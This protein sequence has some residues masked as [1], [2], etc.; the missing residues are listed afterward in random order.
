MQR[1]ERYTYRSLPNVARFSRLDDL[2]IVYSLLCHENH[3]E[4]EDWLEE[5][6]QD[7]KKEQVYIAE[8]IEQA[9][10]RS[11]YLYK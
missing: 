6:R 4:G 9:T 10:L 11:L 1:R 5:R 8:D 3:D 2:P 7:K